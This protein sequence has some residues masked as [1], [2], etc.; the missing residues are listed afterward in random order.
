[1]PLVMLTIRSGYSVCRSRNTVSRISSVCS[2]DTPFTLCEPRKASVPMRTRRPPCSSISDTAASG[3][4]S[5][6]RDAASAS[7]CRPLIW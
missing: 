4:V 1:M 6:G 5:G 3:G 2:A 7:R